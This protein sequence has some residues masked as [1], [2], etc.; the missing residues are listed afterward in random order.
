LSGEPLLDYSQSK[1]RIRLADDVEVNIN[2]MHGGDPI[3]H[4]LPATVKFRCYVEWIS[5]VNL[6]SGPKFRVYVTDFETL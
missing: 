4:T 5:E 1:P 2:E 6:D 3:P